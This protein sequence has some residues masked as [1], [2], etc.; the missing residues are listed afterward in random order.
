MVIF[1]KNNTSEILK[2]FKQKINMQICFLDNQIW[3]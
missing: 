1:E 2:L 3:N